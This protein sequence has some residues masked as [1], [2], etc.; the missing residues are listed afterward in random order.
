MSVDL[1]KHCTGCSACA[2]VCPVKCIRMEDDEEGFARPIIDAAACVECG[3]CERVCPLLGVECF[4]PRK[5]AA[6]VAASP[7]VLVCAASGGAFTSLA[8][9]WL[10]GGGVVVGVADDMITCSSFSFVNNP[11]DLG[12][13]AGSKYYQCNLT[14]EVIGHL[15]ELLSDGVDVLFCGTPCQV[16]AVRNCVSKRLAEK[17]LLVDIVCQGV[18]SKKVV[19]AFRSELEAGCGSRLVRH[20]FRSKR[21]DAGGDYVALLGFENGTEMILE[22]DE[23]LYNRSFKYQVFLRE[24]CY[25][26]PFASA[27]RAG[28]ITLG[29]FWGYPFDNDFKVGS[30]SLVLC[31]TEKGERAASRLTET[32]RVRQA[33]IALAIAGNVPLRHPVGRP[34]VR[35]ISYRLLDTLGF[36]RA[37]R[38]CCWKHTVKRLLKGKGV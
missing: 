16:A 9:Q 15:R 18:P 31:N 7:E 35:S 25:A 11:E 6:Y 12:L 5:A 20:V 2:S 22:G 34:R 36:A 32:G 37:T 30:T 27:E 1:G 13:L 4:K 24:S 14:P 19:A 26:C 28:D 38:I 29:D 10:N 21:A 3:A 33:D 17:L 23:D 8:R